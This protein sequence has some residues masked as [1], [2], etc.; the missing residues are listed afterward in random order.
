MGP[1]QISGKKKWK[2]CY[3]SFIFNSKT[4]QKTLHY[5]LCFGAEL[6]KTITYVYC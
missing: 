3:C 6:D 1:F 2:I 5:L 4:K